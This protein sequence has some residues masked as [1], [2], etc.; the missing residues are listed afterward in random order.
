MNLS[1]LALAGAIAGLL[2]AVTA[3][4]QTGAG[5]PTPASV[6]ETAF[7]YNS[8]YAQDD[9]KAPA[10]KPANA[11]PAAGEACATCNTCANSCCN[12]GCGLLAPGSLFN[13]CCNLGEQWKIFNCPC[14]KANNINIAGY[15]AQSYNQNT[16]HPADGFNGPVTWTDRQGY[17]LNQ[18]YL[19]AE[20]TTNTGGCGTDFGW[21]GDIM[22]GTDYRFNTEGGLETRGPVEFQN[23]RISTQRFYGTAFT[24]LYAEFAVDD[25]KIKVGRW[26]APVGYEVVMTNANFFPSLPMT[27]QYG[28]PFTMSGVV[29]TYQ[30]NA[31]TSIVLGINHGWDNFDNQ[32]N[33]HAGFVGGYNEKFSDGSSIALANTIGDEPTANTGANGSS[34][35]SFRYLQTNVY[36]R[37]LKQISDKL[38]Y[39]AQS[40]FGTQDGA[41]LQGKNA[42]W[43]GLNQYLFYKV[44]DCLTYGIRYEWFRD[45]D[46]FRVGGFL[47]DV[48]GQPGVTRGLSDNRSNYAGSFYEITLGANYKFSANTMIRPYARFDWFSGTSGNPNHIAGNPERP[49]DGGF[50]NSQSLLGFDL[51]TLY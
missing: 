7:E 35:T 14:L 44:S 12:D 15:M 26:Y 24:Q 11:A 34:Q 9:A 16:A 28:E 22:F 43:Y 45:Q 17:E 27:F 39:V 41:T 36:S 19:Y 21:R 49:Y 13:P 50:G 4:A 33:P 5:Q 51:I 37:P 25:W 20:K 47:G 42:K 6:Q 23:P 3:N 2:S 1:K 32:A 10:E 38:T 8:Y 30:V 46:G 40:D 29:G 31:D 48:P 18:L